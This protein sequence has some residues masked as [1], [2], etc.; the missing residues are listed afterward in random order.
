MHKLTI[1]KYTFQIPGNWNELTYEQLRVVFIAHKLNPSPEY[2]KLQLL[3][4]T[5]GIAKLKWKR[6]VRDLMYIYPF[7]YKYNVIWLAAVDIAHIT[8]AFNFLFTDE[9][10]FAP[11]LTNMPLT[12]LRFKKAYYGPAAAFT[13]L[14]FGEWVATETLMARYAE[15]NDVEYL[16]RFFATLW[17]TC[18]K[19][20]WRQP[21]AENSE[22]FWQEF[23]KL[24]SWKA[25][26]IL[27]WYDSCCILLQ[28]K[29]SLIFPKPNEEE[30]KKPQRVIAAQVFDSFMNILE[31]LVDHDVTKKPEVRAQFLYDALYTWEDLI[32]QN[33]KME[34]L[35][36]K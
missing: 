15:T 8:S 23:K 12:V 26:L 35:T 31:M 24:E 14:T 22:D 20:N 7:R 36:N 10:F 18:D 1:D 13:N 3:K 17:R 4:E 9:G 29:F 28:N 11:G 19:E 5:T 32:V 34:E 6:R 25:Q 16:L 2:V 21:L 27:H 30:N 33:K